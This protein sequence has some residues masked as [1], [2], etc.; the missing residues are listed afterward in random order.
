[1]QIETIIP[2]FLAHLK[3]EQSC[4]PLTLDSYQWELN[5]LVDYLKVNELPTNAA[6]VRTPMLRRYILEVQ[7]AGDFKPATVARKV[8]TLRSFFGYCLKQEYAAD[9]PAAGLNAPNPPKPIPAYL[10]PS[11]LNRLFAV[12]ER[13]KGRGAARTHEAIVK[14]LAWTGLRRAELCRLKW[15]DVDFGHK[16]I[17]VRDGKGGKDRVIPM[18]E[19]LSEYLWTYLQGQVPLKAPTVFCTST[20]APYDPPSIYQIVKKLLTRAGITKAAMG[21]HVLRHTFATVLLQTGRVDLVTLQKLLG[22]GHLQTVLIYAHADDCSMK[23]AI[24]QFPM[25]GGG[26]GNVAQQESGR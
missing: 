17:T 13:F 3:V 1:M 15:G 22:H 21:P 5:R 23:A 11:E 12:A 2:E 24:A 18:H 16:T 7:A 8:F 25:Q 20:G 14:T 9:N 10:T 6:G 19:Q 4:S 26:D